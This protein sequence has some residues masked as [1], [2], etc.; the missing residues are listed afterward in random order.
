MIGRIVDVATD[1]L[2]LNVHRG[3]LVVRENFRDGDEIGRVPIN[4]VDG[5]IIHANAI[6]I[7][8][9]LTV[10]LAAQGSPVVY[11]N[12][13]HQ[14]VAFSLPLVGHHLQARRFDAQLEASRPTKKRAWA[15]IVRSKVL[16]QAAVLE[17][18]GQNPGRLKALA[19]QVKS[20]D[21]KNIEGQAARIYWQKLMGPKFRRQRDSKDITNSLLNYGYAVIRASV[22]RAVV[23]AGL[24]PTLAVFH[25]NEGNPLRLVDDLME[26][27]RPFVDLR[28]WSLVNSG[29]T[30]IDSQSKTAMVELL[31]QDLEVD[32]ETTPVGMAASHLASSLARIYLG[33]LDAIELFQPQIP[34][35]MAEQAHSVLDG[36]LAC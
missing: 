16:Q 3:F 27:F 17:V 32:G 34:Q 23:A 36:E 13:F 29:T 31:S 20:G 24:H 9:A 21:P 8:N 28:V 15:D 22:A 6:M 2:S 14:V 11:C 7:S 25:Q 12:P 4:D 35:H 30:N 33:E 10:R 18:V 1:G 19:G 26:P 5:L